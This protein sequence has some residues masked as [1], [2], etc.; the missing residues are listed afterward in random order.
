[1]AIEDYCDELD[2]LLAASGEDSPGLDEVHGFMCAALCGPR[3]LSLQDCVCALF[4]AEEEEGQSSECELP[5]ELLEM[6]D[7]LYEDTLRSIKDGSFL[8]IVA[9]EADEDAE[10]EEKA[11]ARSWCCGFL[12]GM[13]QD[14]SRWKLDNPQVLDLLAPIILLAEPKEF[15]QTAA[16]IR[17]INP[18]DFKQELLE[19]LPVSVPALKAF[20]NKKPRS[21]KRSGSP[22]RRNS[23]R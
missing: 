8:P 1:M 15:E 9:C 6:L 20:F 21:P 17:D 18:D 14:R 10:R 11:D 22:K 4:L 3:V 5:E 2:A 16:Q 12:L 23:R 7:R 19:A 13:E